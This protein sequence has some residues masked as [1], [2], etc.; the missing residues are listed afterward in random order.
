[1]LKSTTSPHRNDQPSPWV[2]RF[3]PLVPEG[4]VLDLACGIGRHS[5]LFAAGHRVLAVDRDSDALA[6]IAAEGI[7]T[8]Q[9]DLENGGAWPFEKSRFAGI[10]IT[11]YLHRPL[12][13]FI[14]D[15]LADDG[16][17]IV[18]TFAVGNGQ[19]GKPS[20]PDFLLAPGELLA[21][22][23]AYVNANLRIIAYEDG[24][25]EKPQPAMIQRVCLAKTAFCENSRRFPLI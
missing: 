14:F 1:M 4:E 3:A 11:N 12:F 20:N 8:L 7:A 21:L 10:V 5:R 15:S 6:T 19:F 24:Y 22:A 13:P 17:L 23:G 16:I 2:Q 18:E 25:V 9:A